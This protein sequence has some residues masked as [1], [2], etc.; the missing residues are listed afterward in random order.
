MFVQMKGHALS[1]VGK[2]K[3]RQNRLR[4]SQDYWVRKLGFTC[5]KAS[6]SVDSSM[7]ANNA[8]LGAREVPQ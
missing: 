5:M 6:Y 2:I 1:Q 4:S 7:C 3:K 8:P